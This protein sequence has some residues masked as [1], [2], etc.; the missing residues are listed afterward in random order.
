MSRS[1]REGESSTLSNTSKLRVG[2][3]NVRSLRSAIKKQ[4]LANDFESY[5]LDILGLT[6]TWLDGTG[7]DTLGNGHQLYRSG[8]SNGRAGVGIVINRK[9]KNNVCSY[10]FHSP[11]IVSV[12]LR[13]TSRPDSKCATVVCCYAP[14]LV[15]STQDPA[16]A[17]GFYSMLSSVI[18]KVKRRDEVYV[19]G[20][21]NAKVASARPNQDG[22]V[23][24]YSKHTVGNANGDRLIELCEDHN[25]II[26]NTLF[27]HRMHH[28]STWFA[29][30]LVHS[31]GKPVRN[32]IDYI[33]VKKT[34]VTFVTN[35]RSY[36]GFGTRSDHHPVIAD[37][38]ISFKI[39]NR[40][41]IPE[42]NDL[43]FKV[44]NPPSAD[45]TR[46]YQR[47]ISEQ[48]PALSTT[49]STAEDMELCWT[50]F[51]NTVHEAAAKAFGVVPR[52][53]KPKRSTSK[54]VMELSDQQKSLHI[55][56]QAESDT[57]RRSQLKVERAAVL[58]RLR[59]VLRKE[60]DQ[61]WQE[62]AESVDAKRPDSRS[63]FKAI[64]DLKA[65]R[66]GG[67][68]QP[69]NLA[70]EDG[71]LVSDT[72]WNTAK[73]SEY[74][75][76]I[77]R[78]TDH[79][80]RLS[81]DSLH[82][83]EPY[84]TSETVKA[85]N[86][87]HPGKSVGSDGISAEM[88]QTGGSCMSEWLTEF[89]CCL[90]SQRMCP[91]DLRTGLLVPLYKA[92]KPLGIPKSFRPVMLLSTV[93]KVL[94]S[95]VVRRSSSGVKEYVR[96][97]QAGF[98]QGRSTADG[99][100][101]TRCMCE[102]ALLGDWTYAAALLD[103]SGA[104]D[105]IERK[106]AMARLTEAGIPTTTSSVLTSNTSVSVKL[107]GN[108]GTPFSTNMG[109]VQGD[110]ASP[111]MFIVYTET[112]LRRIETKI[113]RPAGISAPPAV[114]T[115]YADDTTVHGRDIAEVKETVSICEEEFKKDNLKLNMDKT[116]FV[117]PTR[118]NDAWK[119]VKLLG[120]LLGTAE[121]VRNRMS[122][123]NRHFGSI[124]WHR[125]SL[126]SRLCMFSV[127]ILPVLLYNCALWTLTAALEKKLDIWHRKKLRQILKIAYPEWISNKALYS[128]TDQLPLGIVCRRR[129]LLWFGHVVREGAG[130]ASY[131][132]MMMCFHIS[133]VKKPRGRPLTRW[134]DV[135]KRDLMQLDLT[136]DDALQIS[137]D[138]DKWILVVNRCV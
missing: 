95:I 78:N 5:R 79:P 66:Q 33:M 57:E 11:R 6:E 31:D 21:M 51:K 101:Y 36:G 4:T 7:A 123:A 52:N 34:N 72:S 129:R 50:S 48:L 60:G 116:Q 109:V 85:I 43:C 37:L 13:L 2:T 138:K 96:E 56:I 8:G 80:D 118:T 17:D 122:A 32:M 107:N 1:E 111:L 103:F 23:G 100:F 12:R 113:P 90:Q 115:E 92:G 87:L 125:H 133:D 132:A 106:K 105:T 124:S 41:R 99:V 127:L 69:I 121:D 120:S 26:C 59:S 3:F 137:Q 15:K 97:S 91:E 84:S 77:F 93:R 75:S 42:S 53:K 104:F 81:P 16:E 44:Y 61:F 55:R 89:F 63:Y 45:S 67:C 25:L 54:L 88:I 18:S 14:T 30:G 47:I 112:T 27:K 68:R 135:V 24:C 98:R 35:A 102:R 10:C 29:D 65:M 71:D 38:Y 22:P 28:R 134:T 110:P 126:S 130:S 46:V 94:T 74:F 73:F 86:A 58:H 62:Q 119:S 40:R 9:L 19:M 114:F 136:I 82:P 83:E 70:N 64:R 131:E 108:I 39:I 117:A 20:D 49:F 128:R 76:G